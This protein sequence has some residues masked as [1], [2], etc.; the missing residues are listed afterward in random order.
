VTHEC[1]AGN[2]WPASPITGREVERL[3]YY[4]S[5]LVQKWPRTYS[6]FIL[7]F[8]WSCSIW[9]DHPLLRFSAES[10][11]IRA[12]FLDSYYLPPEEC[13]AF[14][15]HSNAVV[16]IARISSWLRWLLGCSLYDAAGGL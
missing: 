10:T 4:T 2:A 15:Q 3:Y 6:T 5:P 16:E 12:Y 14:W 13:D 1:E 7:L 11:A 8:S 9:D